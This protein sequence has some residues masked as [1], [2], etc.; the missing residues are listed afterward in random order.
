PEEAWS[1]ARPS[2]VSRT[3]VR[4]GPPRPLPVPHH[5]PRAALRRGINHLGG[6]TL[7]D[8]QR[9]LRLRKTPRGE[10]SECFLPVFRRDRH[11]RQRLRRVPFV[12]VGRRAFLR[13]QTTTV[14]LA[15]TASVTT[16]IMATSTTAG[17]AQKTRRCTFCPAGIVIASEHSASGSDARSFFRGAA[18][19][20]P[21]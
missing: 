9:E 2:H 12:C 21:F 10:D 18:R 20:P 13:C 5:A 17:D 4:L 7:L 15:S 3:S 6:R 14:L 11:G 19:R 1:S 8:R 16:P